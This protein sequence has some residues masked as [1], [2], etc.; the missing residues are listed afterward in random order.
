MN[1]P[2]VRLINCSKDIIEAVLTSDAVLAKKLGIIVPDKWSEFGRVAF[3][4]TLKELELNPALQK[5]LTYLPVHIESNT[6]IGSCGYKGFPNEHG[7]VE[8]GYEVSKVFRNQGLAT[9]MANLLVAQ[10]FED[11]QVKMVWAHT[12]AEEN[13]SVHVLRKCGFEFGKKFEEES[14]GRIWRWIRKKM[15]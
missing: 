10:A 15:G 8:I 12:S 7:M 13:A 9:E 1:A 3:T 5:W 11:D 6:L 4:Y 14:E 2:R